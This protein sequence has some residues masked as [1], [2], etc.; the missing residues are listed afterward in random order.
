MLA[1]SDFTLAY[2]DIFIESEPRGQYAGTFKKDLKKKK[3]MF[4]SSARKISESF[5]PIITYLG[6]IL[7]ENR[8]RSDLSRASA[9]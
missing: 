9:I 6:Q 2:L 8:R 4:L 7:D 3:I 1:G 5:I